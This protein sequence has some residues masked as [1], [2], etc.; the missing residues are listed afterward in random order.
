MINSSLILVLSDLISV[1]SFCVTDDVEAKISARV[2]IGAF[3]R[4]SIQI[5]RLALVT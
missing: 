4:H 1:V 5:F 2:I 3:F